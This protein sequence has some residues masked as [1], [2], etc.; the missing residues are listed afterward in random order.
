[1]RRHHPSLLHTAGS[2]FYFRDNADSLWVCLFYSSHRNPILCIFYWNFDNLLFT[3]IKNLLY[4]IWAH[5][6]RERALWVAELLV[7]YVQRA[8]ATDRKTNITVCGAFS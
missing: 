3:L 2:L 7:V 1:M 8:N 6:Y 4:V 5:S